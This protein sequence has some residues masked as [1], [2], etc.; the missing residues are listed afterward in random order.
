MEKMEKVEKKK[1]KEKEK[2][3]K[4]KEKEKKDSDPEAEKRNMP[5]QLVRSPPSPHAYPL[6]QWVS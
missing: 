2:K 1:E 6:P 5:P 3:K 4:K